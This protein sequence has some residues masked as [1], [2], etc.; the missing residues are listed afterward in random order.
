MAGSSL[1]KEVNSK[2]LIRVCNLL[3]T[4]TDEYAV[5]FGTMLGIHRDGD[6]IDG[7]DDCDFYLPSK[8]YNEVKNL[9]LSNGYTL[10]PYDTKDTFTQF[11]TIIDSQEVLIDLYYYFDY[12]EDYVIDKWNFFGQPHNPDKWIA[13]PKHALF[14]FKPVTYKGTTILTPNNPEYLCKYLYGERYKEKLIK[15]K[16]YTMEI[17]GNFP[18]IIYINT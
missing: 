17:I 18:Q 2:N 11:K 9:L 7:D 4:I 1:P 16:E 10:S 12:D 5:F 3:N 13:I 6:V 8:L 15:G 14:D